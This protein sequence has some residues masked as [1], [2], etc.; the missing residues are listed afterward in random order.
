MHAAPDAQFPLPPDT[1]IGEWRLEQYVAGGTYGRVYRAVPAGDTKAEPYALKLARHPEDARFTREAELLSRVRHP[2]VPRLYGCGTYRDEKGREFPYLVME[3]IFGESLYAWGRKREASP[4]QVLKVLAQVARALEAT[5]V[6]GVHRDVKGDNVRV[7]ADGRATLL[8]FGSCW[9]PEATVLTDSHPPGTEAYRSHPLARERAQ[10]PQAGGAYHGEP[11]DDVYALGVMAYRLVTGKYPPAA[12]AGERPLPPSHHAP[13]SPQLDKLLLRMLSEKPAARGAAG[14]VAREL[15]EASATTAATEPPPKRIP[16][17]EARRRRWP[18]WMKTRE[19]KAVLGL[20]VA[21]VPLLG[22][23]L[24]ASYLRA[25]S[26]LRGPRD[27]E[28]EEDKTAVGKETLASAGMP[29]E[30]GVPGE[31]PATMSTQ[32][33]EKPLKGQKRPPCTQGQVEINKGCWGPIAVEAPCTQ[34]RYYYEWNGACYVPIM[35]PERP[36]TSRDP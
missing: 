5:H 31:T 12:E 13:V 16:P 32:V 28:R 8:D 2:G 19:A 27:Q 33:P 26:K 24:A 17:Q 25:E 7:G 4:R 6:H 14:K 21:V 29:E 3:F 35:H 9:F 34:A 20:V 11:A 10:G 30:G 18:W 36:P 15:E 22:V 23:D 1:R